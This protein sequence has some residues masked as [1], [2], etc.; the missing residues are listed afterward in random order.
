MHD[1]DIFTYC[2]LGAFAVAIPFFAL[3]LLMQFYRDNPKT[4]FFSRNGLKTWRVLQFIAIIIA[5][6]AGA[7]GVTFAFLHVSLPIATLF[8]SSVY[9]CI[10][11]EAYC[12]A[13]KLRNY[14]KIPLLLLLVLLT[15]VL[16]LY[17]LKV[18]QW[19]FKSKS[20]VIPTSPTKSPLI[21]AG[22]D[23]T[24]ADS[25]LFILNTSRKITKRY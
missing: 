12:A 10:S 15:L 14:Y 13:G 24:K 22:N 19:L 3:I 9:I 11:I 21:A 1:Y 16:F 5:N 7:M 20:P 8:V 23:T 4:G 17:G 25:G 2:A 6:G 18:G